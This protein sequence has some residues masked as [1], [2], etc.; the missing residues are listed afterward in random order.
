MTCG[1]P[2]A[3]SCVLPCFA[4][5]NPAR[6]LPWANDSFDAV[7]SSDALE[8][9]EPADVRSAVS[10]ISRVA[11]KALVLKVSNRNDLEPQLNVTNGTQGVMVLPRSLHPTVHWPGWGLHARYDDL[12]WMILALS[13]MPA[14]VKKKLEVL[15]C[16]RPA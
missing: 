3:P 4:Q 10:E 7:V 6:G 2:Q 16:S 13:N 1:R 8:H 15:L 5:A 11:T 14:T 12:I 9:I